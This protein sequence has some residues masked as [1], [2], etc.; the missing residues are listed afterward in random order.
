VQSQLKPG[1]WLRVLM[2]FCIVAVVPA[3]VYSGDLPPPLMLANWVGLIAGTIAILADRMSRRARQLRLNA[4]TAAL[5]G[6]T[7]LLYLRPFL[8]GGRL[9]VPCLLGRTAD[10]WIMG[11]F[12][13]LELAIAL[14]V[15][16]T[17]PLVA[18]G[19]DPNAFGAAKFASTDDAWQGF[20][21]GLADK[22]DVIAIVPFTRPG[23]LWEIKT[24]FA[25][26]DLLRKTV[27]VMPP[28]R[29]ARML[30]D[31]LAPGRRRIAA[32]WRDAAQALAKDGIALPA[33]RRSG[34][35]LMH[36]GSVFHVFDGHRFRPNYLAEL[37]AELGGHGDETLAPATLERMRTVESRYGNWRPVMDYV[38]SVSPPSA[39]LALVLAFAIRAFL[40]HPFQVP[41]GS[42]KDTLLIG[43]YLVVAKYAYG[44]S[45]YSLPGSAHLFSGR[46]W[47]AAPQYGDVVVFRTPS[48]DQT[49][50]I[51][52]VVGLPGDRIQMIGGVLNING[53]PVEQ[54]RV[55]DFVDVEDGQPTRARRWRETLP[56]GV[57][58]TILDL[59]ED[60]TYDNT[61]LYEVPPGHYFMMG[62]NRDNATD[63]R[64]ASRVGFVPF[65]NI[66]GR[67][68]LVVFSVAE[69]ENFWAVWRWPW[70][71]RRD[72]L[73]TVVK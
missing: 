21:T 44:Y 40:F 8:T 68:E 69:G 28:T 22:A 41:S 31:A 9:P 6:G 24:V 47:A 3:T 43:D 65:E 5:A 59:V 18:L 45:R 52:R 73:F 30:V 70:T 50:F 60:G 17:R 1:T 19:D 14:A 61:P 35:L 16:D 72:R 53:R 12:W 62:D 48:D 71:I 20:I 29:W 34:A 39:I 23:T 42:M 26:K 25:R 27:L 33:Y 13:D 32:Y 66:V 63:S 46:I 55:D 38:V 10:R 51:Q 64:I 54:E 56:N 36:D 7:Y 2:W 4:E 49:D 11:R 37:F 67:A 57:S 15:E 58:H